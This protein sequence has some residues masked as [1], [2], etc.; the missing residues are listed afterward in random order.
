MRKCP[1]CGSEFNSN[2]CP[3]CGT[4]AD[5]CE[6]IAGPAPVAEAPV[7]AKKKRGP[8]GCLI[9]VLVVVA[10][11][12]VLGALGSGDEASSPAAPASNSSSAAAS[13]SEPIDDNLIDTDIGDTH[14]VYD[15]YDISTIADAKYITVYYQFTNNS[16]SNRIF[17]VTVSAQAF[18][19]GVEL[20][21][22]VMYTS[23][24][25]RTAEAEIKP[26]VT[27]LVARAYRLQDDSP[28]LLEVSPFISFSDDATDSATIE[29][30]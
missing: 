12:A 6:Q 18:Q 7:K 4:P 14:V 25:T 21:S 8:K 11:I 23:E 30:E 2:F 5:Q 15:H 20:Q 29:L 22:S 10:L 26:G 13:A 16:D 24:E 1:K 27:S 17:Y 9:V 3:N 28:V 19:N